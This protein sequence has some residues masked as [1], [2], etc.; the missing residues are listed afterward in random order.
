MLD[1]FI[2]DSAEETSIPGKVA[3]LE[4]VAELLVRVKNPTTRELYAGRLAVVLGLQPHQVTRALREAANKAHRAP[5]H[6][7]AERPATV[8]PPA[9]PAKL[10]AE[11]LHVIVLLARFP[12]LFRTPA[13]AR[14]GDL[15]VHP[16]LRQ[17]HRSAARELSENAGRMDVSAWLDG[18]PPAE[19]AAVAAS[20]MDGVVADVADPPKHLEKLVVRLELLRVEAEIAMN[21]R[22]QREAQTRGDEAALRALVARGIE[23]RK[24]KEGLKAALQRP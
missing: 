15:L 8:A 1:Q 14:A 5:G 9:A 13:A 22:L 23:L 11:E 20:L 2:Q 19:R 7:A 21:A 24:T 16:V 3:T 18:A 12:E 6:V 10:P 17:L 4:R